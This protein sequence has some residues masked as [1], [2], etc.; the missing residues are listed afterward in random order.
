MDHQNLN[1]KNFNTEC[2][3]RWCLIIEEFGQTIQSIKGPKNIV[4]DTV[5]H[6]DILPYE[7]CLNIADCYGLNDDDLSSD[8]FPLTYSLIDHEQQKDEIILARAQKAQHYSV[9]KFD[10]CG[11]AIHE[12]ICFKD[13]I[14][15]VLTSLQKHIIQWYHYLLCHPGINRIEETL[16][17]HFY[18]PK[19]RDQITKD[20]STCGIC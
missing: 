16:G 9:K 8:S 6:L 20:I 11:N 14:V 15:V 5:S 2:V 4:A 19:M 12:L 7:K 10:G 17:Q 13:K 1:Y 3:M 18:W